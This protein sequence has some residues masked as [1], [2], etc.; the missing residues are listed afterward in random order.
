MA[1]WDW[2]QRIIGSENALSKS[3]A[4]SQPIV[5]SAKA[6][7]GRDDIIAYAVKLSG[8]VLHQPDAMAFYHTTFA[9][10]IDSQARYDD[11]RK[12]GDLLDKDALKAHGLRSNV[13]VS[14]Q[15]LATLNDRGCSDPLE[16]AGVIGLTI[17]AALCSWRDLEGFKSK[18][19]SEVKLLAADRQ[20]GPCASA[21]AIQ[22][23]KQPT[24]R[25]S[26]L[27]FETC[28]RLGR[29]ACTYLGWLPIMDELGIE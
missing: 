21:A 5:Q 2:L 7:T 6:R 9:D 18:G 23:R 1:V 15:F 28:D 13:K 17:S 22:D 8:L 20:P 19:I 11:F 3:M 25:A 16:A 10:Y 14:A 24:T 27:P 26:I 12:Q 4:P 29:C